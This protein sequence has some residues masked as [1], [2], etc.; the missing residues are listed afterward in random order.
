MHFFKH[1]FIIMNFCVLCDACCY[2]NDPD[3]HLKPLLCHCRFP[4]A[5]VLVV[6]F[7]IH[8]VDVHLFASLFT[9]LREKELFVLMLLCSDIPPLLT[10]CL[11]KTMILLCDFE[12][13]C[14]GIFVNTEY[15]FLPL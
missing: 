12:F 4:I 8:T 3:F 11:F 14:F 9:C 7:V 13:I 1:L 5:F 6:S 15:F 10:H 2:K